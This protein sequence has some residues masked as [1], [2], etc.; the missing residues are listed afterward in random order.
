MSIAAMGFYGSKGPF[1]AMPPMFLTGTAAAGAIAWINSLG[2]L[3]GFFGSWYV[4]VMK[5]LTGSYA[6]GLYG[7]A[8]FGLISAFISAFFLHIPNPAASA[9]ASAAIADRAA[10]DP[11]PG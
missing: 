11:I 7:Q 8:L 1:W 6:G 4:G 2:N 5:A 3:G 9:R 10:L